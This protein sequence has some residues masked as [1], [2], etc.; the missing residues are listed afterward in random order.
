MEF[1]FRTGFGVRALL[2]TCFSASSLMAQTV[3]PSTPQ[4][5]PNSRAPDTEPEPF[6]FRH[7]ERYSRGMF[8]GGIVSTSVGG[9]F[10]LAST[11]ILV[12]PSSDPDT[13]TE[14]NRANCRSLHDGIRNVGYGGLGVGLVG[15]AVGVPL[16]LVGGRSVS[17]RAALILNPSS[18]LLC[19]TW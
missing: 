16:I 17:A 19:G 5:A 9:F 7:A 6:Q 2:V 11:A 14:P 8:I 13:C 3:Y 10:A 12:S 18:L 15:V 4:P 1:V